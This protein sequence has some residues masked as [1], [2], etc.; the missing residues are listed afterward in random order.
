MEN[1]SVTKRII[2]SVL[3]LSLMTSIGLSD[4]SD[5]ALFD[6][7]G[8][9]IVASATTPT[10]V[11]IKDVDML[12]TDNMVYESQYSGSAQQY[13]GTYLG[14]PFSTAKTG[15]ITLSMT[16]TS[17]KLSLL[18]LNSGGTVIGSYDFT[19]KSNETG[20]ITKSLSSGNY[21]AVIYNRGITSTT[22]FT[23][24]ISSSTVFDITNTKATSSFKN[25]P[26]VPTYIITYNGTTL[27]KGTDYKVLETNSSSSKNSNGDTVYSY[28]VKI[29]GMGNY[30][31]T[32]TYTFTNTVSNTKYIDL[33]G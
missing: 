27:V 13:S 16:T 4:V 10:S 22:G 6:A 3:A 32:K 30:T 23:M 14:M 19:G 15:K 11:A 29:Q 1:N 8:S 2:T 28:V 33:G 12:S 17:N 25:N 31:G 20:S 5:Y 21:Y 7:T 9:T 26:T 24:K 18:I